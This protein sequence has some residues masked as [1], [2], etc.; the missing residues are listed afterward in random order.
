M[1]ISMR[2][3]GPD[4]VPAILGMLDS[5]VEWLVEQGRTGQWGTEPHSM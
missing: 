5:C 4:D 1:E 2:E 3:G